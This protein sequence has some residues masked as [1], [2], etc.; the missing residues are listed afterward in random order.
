MEEYPT[1][2]KFRTWSNLFHQKALTHNQLF[3]ASPADINDPFDFKI[4]IDYSLLD[5]GAKREK[6]VTQLVSETLETIIRKG[7]SP[8][9]KKEELLY[10]LLFDRDRMQDEFNQ[11]ANLWTNNR[12][13]VISFS[14]RWD[15]ILLWSH[16]AE[17]HKGFCIGYNKQKLTNSNLFDTAGPVN[18]IDSY[19]RLDPLNIDKENEAFTKTYSKASDWEYEKEFRLTKLWPNIDPSIK[20]RTIE[21]QNDYAEEIILGMNISQEHEKAI[22]EIAKQKGIKVYKIGSKRN[23]FLLEKLAY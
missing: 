21:V 16:Y 1:I 12:F 10:R 8:A 19:P 22:R 23:S 5:S 18:Y 17:N 11:T 9:Q 7:I 13:G 2:Y 15:S 6:Y 14:L 4:N 3:Y 20:E